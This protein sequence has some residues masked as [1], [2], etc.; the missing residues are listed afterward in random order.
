MVDFVE[1]IEDGKIVKVSENYAKSEKL[2][3]VRKREHDLPFSAH[4]QAARAVK[5]DPAKPYYLNN[6]LNSEL[7]ENFH[8]ELQKQRRL[9]NLG[10]KQLSRL[11]GVPENNIIELEN[12]NVASNFIGLAKLEA[13]YG[14]NLRK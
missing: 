2:L 7:K 10:R 4:P 1:A 6:N 13:F 9:R 3:I 12:G 14:I 5:A 8:W 11:S